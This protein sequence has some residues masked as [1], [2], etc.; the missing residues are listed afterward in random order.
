[1]LWQSR[2][3]CVARLQAQYC[4]CCWRL[5]HVYV[6]PRLFIAAWCWSLMGEEQGHLL[7]TPLKMLIHSQ[8]GK[9][10]NTIRLQVLRYI[11]IIIIIYS[12]VRTGQLLS[13]FKCSCTESV[14]ATIRVFKSIQIICK[15]GE[16]IKLR[17]FGVLNNEDETGHQEDVMRIYNA[18]HGKEETYLKEIETVFIYLFFLFPSSFSPVDR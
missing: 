14:Q 9:S 11:I 17:A 10:L 16:L 3:N 8:R 5:C 1:M 4:I 12:F 15:W 7:G 2:P 13:R 6:N 18:N